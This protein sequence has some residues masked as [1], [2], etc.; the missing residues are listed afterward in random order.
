MARKRRKIQRSNF[1]MD[2]LRQAA[3]GQ[4]D[5]ILAS[6][7]KLTLD[8]LQVGRQGPCPQCGGT[9]R[10]GVFTKDFNQTGGVTCRH[11]FNKKNGDG[12]AA[13]QWL[14][15]IDFLDALEFVANFVGVKPSGKRPAKRRPDENLVF[16]DWRPKLV[17][18][19]CSRKPGITPEA[20]QAVG[21]RIARYRDQYTV[22]AIPIWGPKLRE[23]DP[24]G[25]VC[26]NSTGLTLPVFRPDGQNPDWVDKKT[27]PGSG[28]GV[29]GNPDEIKAA[30]KIW[31]LEGVTDVLTWFSI[32]TGEGHT[33]F[34]NVHGCQESPDEA[35]WVLE[36]FSGSVGAVLHDADTPGQ[37]GALGWDDGGRRRPG[38]AERI[39]AH[40]TE[41]RN[42]RLPFE[43]A[44][45][46][47]KDFRD[48]ILGGG[49]FDQLRELFE[50]SEVIMPTEQLPNEKDDDP[51]RL[52]RVNAAR[53]RAAGGG[54]AFWADAVYTYEKGVYRHESVKRMR[55]KL[56]EG[57]NTEFER[58]YWIAKAEYDERRSAGTLD[59]DAKEPVKRAPSVNLTNAVFEATHSLCR[60]PAGAT[61]NTW[62]P[63]GEPRNY[64]S[65]ANGILDVDAVL[66]DKDQCLMPHT[67]DWFSQIKLDYPFDPK[68]TCP[69]WLAF[70]E[71][72]LEGDQQRI[73]LVQEWAG[74][75]LLPDTSK[76][77]FMILEGEGQN[78]KSVYI[79]GIQAI[80]GG[81]QNCSYVPLEDFD[82]PFGLGSSLG[83]LVNISADA[84]E[85]DRTA[86]GRIKAIVS[87][88]NMAF[89]R[90]YLEPIECAPTARLMIACNHRPHFRDRTSGLWRRM[91]LVPWLIQIPDNERVDGMDERKWWIEQGEVSGMLNWALIGRWRLQNY[92]FTKSDVVEAA[93]EDF[94]R[95]SNPAKRFLVE[96]LEA[97]PAGGPGIKCQKL[98]QMYQQW[99]KDIGGRGSLGDKEFGKE[100]FRVFPEV[101]KRK[102]GPRDRR[103]YAYFGIDFCEGVFSPEDILGVYIDDF[104]D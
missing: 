44:E 23:A 55:A 45:S 86:E 35:K 34:T 26:M 94:R 41:C 80:L 38:W 58:L 52:A 14:M 51:W 16:E 6:T 92:G 93:L 57:I 21:A 46:K 96:H 24:I 85:V 20:L 102:R 97:V 27:M 18:L 31:K 13:V 83:K 59:E 17:A 1:D 100:L 74:Y 8:Q 81:K 28:R 42:V 56:L 63:T 2:V 30:G 104:G 61:L 82:K 91:F 87:G 9:D 95:D 60:M 64:I 3:A 40:A 77:K 68:A 78:G 29:I 71:R 12:F 19:W 36:L 4:W 47:G 33:A 69:K 53:M 11:C 73:N 10:F 7:G 99:S 88:D 66:A 90:K 62:I 103:T 32:P 15:G 79:A 22:I 5:R 48:F 25:W 76:H 70:L 43:V 89:D 75:L 72:N 50:K 65:V 49:T 67:P 37:R 54:I 84:G 98:F 101:A 39:A